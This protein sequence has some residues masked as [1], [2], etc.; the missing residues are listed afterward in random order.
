MPAPPLPTHKSDFTLGH[1]FE[2]AECHAIARMLY[3]AV[4]C[5]A[6]LPLSLIRFQRVVDTPPVALRE[7]YA[8][9]A[10]LARG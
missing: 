2:C 6:D 8:A 9:L 10:A 7:R 5:H 4:A 1:C 3:V